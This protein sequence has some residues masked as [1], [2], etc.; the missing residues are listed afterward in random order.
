MAY[1]DPTLVTE[2]VTD[3]YA[4]HNGGTVSGYGGKVPT[5]HRIRYDGRMRRV[6]VMQYGNSGSAYIIVKGSDVFL[7]V[8]TEHKV[9]G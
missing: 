2:I 4:P 9:R 5:R 6:Y 7:D 1:T 3:D 8:E